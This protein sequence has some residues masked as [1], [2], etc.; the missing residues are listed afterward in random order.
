MLSH[1][2]STNLLDSTMEVLSP[3][4]TAA[5]PQSGT[6]VISDWLA[7]LRQT[8]NATELTNVLEQVKTELESDQVNTGE[9]AQLLNQLATLTLEFSTRMGSEGDIAPRLEGLA[10]AL[11]ELAGQLGHQ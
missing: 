4:S 9:L 2:E 10:S 3:D 7:Q 11:R 8:D 1:E 6:G 5:I